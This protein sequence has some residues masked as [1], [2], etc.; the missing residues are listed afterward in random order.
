MRKPKEI[1][2]ILKTLTDKGYDA[3]CAGQCVAA[4]EM[5]QD[6]LDWDI[7]TDAD[8]EEVRKLFPEGEAIG[9]RVT[10]L[11]NTTEVISD[12]INIPNTFDGVVSDIVTLKG[13][14]EDQL[15]I[16]DFTCEAVGEHSYK[17]PCD[18][19]GGRGDMKKKLLKPTGNIAEAFAKNPMK[20]MKALKYVGLYGFDLDRDIYEAMNNR[21]DILKKAPKEELLYD[22]TEAIN[23]NS[24]G[25]MLKMIKGMNLLPAFIGDEGQSPDRREAREYDLLCENIDKLKHIAQRRLVVFYLVFD[26]HYKKAVSY[27]PHEEEDLELYLETKKALPK[28]HFASD[29]TNLKKFI[30]SVGWDKYNFI[31]K[32]A[33]AQIITMGYNNQRAEGRDEVLKVI[34]RERQPI[35]VEDLRIDADD[36][37]E[38]GITSDP[39][40]AEMLLNLLPD[41]IHKQPYKNDREQLLKYAKAFKKSK[42]RRALR[43]VSWLR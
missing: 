43:D 17:A 6:A 30:Y 7:Y 34:L 13:S 15:A 38:A 12:D 26:R 40:E 10:R 23:G 22:F 33:K 20:M 11:D 24:A 28:L 18:P 4:V 36:I 42:I 35:F 37:V 2:S 8:T 32:V 14:I 5:G 27:L 1:N 29:D 21:A 19:F 39:E 3:W 41:V 16:Y 9:T 31:D 25:K